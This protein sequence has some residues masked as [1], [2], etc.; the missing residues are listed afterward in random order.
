M[1]DIF[2]MK[3][4][5]KTINEAS[6]LYYNTGTSP[7]SDQQFDALVEELKYMEQITGVQLSNSP[8][9]NVGAPVLDSI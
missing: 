3:A 9:R 1:N 6:S 4:L 5:I 2:Q 7:Y 8:L